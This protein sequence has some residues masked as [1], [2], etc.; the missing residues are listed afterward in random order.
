VILLSN[1][2][3]GNEGIQNIIGAVSSEG[4]KLQ[5]LCLRQAGISDP[6]VLHCSAMLISMG[7]S[8]PLTHLD[9]GN[10]LIGDTR[11]E[12]HCLSLVIF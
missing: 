2:K 4:C 3:I 7:T 8:S 10:N 1:N 12:N 6:G 11:S 9:I 5:K